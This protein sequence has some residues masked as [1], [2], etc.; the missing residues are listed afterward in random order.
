MFFQVALKVVVGDAGE[1]ARE[2]ITLLNLATLYQTW[3]RY[4]AA[5]P[6]YQR[7]LSL[8]EQSLGMRHPEVAEVLERY[9]GLLRQH[10]PWRSIL[11][12]SAAVRMS[13]RAQ[14]IRQEVAESSGLKR[15]LE[16]WPKDETD[17]FD[18]GHASMF[19]A[20]FYSV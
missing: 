1:A 12:W 4:T 15:S 9:A 8:R 20:I 13:L 16:A 6:L 14:R 17:V 18:D 2:S 19:T 5:E 3:G 10:Y 11:P 7:A